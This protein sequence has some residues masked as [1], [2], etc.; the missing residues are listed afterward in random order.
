MRGLGVEGWMLSTVEEW[1]QEKERVGE[2]GRVQSRW[3]EEQE[4]VGVW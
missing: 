2:K 1:P 3:R 4:R